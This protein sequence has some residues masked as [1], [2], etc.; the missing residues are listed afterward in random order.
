MQDAF[1]FDHTPGLDEHG[2]PLGSARA[3]GLRPRF[4]DKF[5]ELGVPYDLS[6]FEPGA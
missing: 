5:D 2:R 3:S 4:L 6:L 1:V